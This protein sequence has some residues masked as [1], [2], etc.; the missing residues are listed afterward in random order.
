MAENTSPVPQEL[1]TKP[2]ILLADDSK[3]VRKT[4]SRILGDKFD[5]ILAEDGEEA[6]KILTEDKSIQ[7][8]FSDLGMPN[9]DGYSLIKRIRQS[10]QEHISNIPLIVITGAAEEESIKL[11]VLELG[12]TD[13][14]GKPFKSSE[15]IARADAHASYTNDKTKLQKNTNIDLLTS[16]LNRKAL[17]DKLERDLSFIKRHNQNLALVKFE[18]HDF[19]KITESIGKENAEKIIKSTSNMLNKALRKEDS[20]GRCEY[21]SFLTILPM[22]KTE[23]VVQLAKRLSEVVKSFKA[24]MNGEIIEMRLTVGIATVQKGAS[25]TVDRLLKTVEKALTNARSIEPGQV[26]L[27]KIQQP[28]SKIEEKTISIDKLLEDILQGKAETDPTQLAMAVKQLRPLVKLLS[29]THKR[30]LIQ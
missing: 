22:A 4:A 28:V 29:P 12:A 11:R 14:I 24:K 5:L 26:Q 13:F 18:I 30:Q 23:G 2:R 3:L 25:V 17:L 20:F 21:A 10:D 27:L 8:V 9:L 16:T 1:K 19:K 15:I 7:V 6:W